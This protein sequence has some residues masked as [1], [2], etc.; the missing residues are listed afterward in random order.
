MWKFENLLSFV[1]LVYAQFLISFIK[2]TLKGGEQAARESNRGFTV[3][4]SFPSF[5]V[6]VLFASAAPL[7]KADTFKFKD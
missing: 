2:R 7:L 6:V 3:S 1:W 5:I 4:T